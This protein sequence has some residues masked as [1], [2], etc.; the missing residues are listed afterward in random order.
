MTVRL[1]SSSL[2]AHE[3][4]MNDNKIEKPVE[5]ALQAQASI[6]SS[7]HKHGSSR[8]RGRGRDGSHY[9]KGRAGQNHGGAEQNNTG[10]NHNP[11][12]NSSWQ[13]R[14]RGRG[15]D[16]VWQ[17]NTA[18]DMD[19]KKRY[20]YVLNEDAEDGVNLETPA[21]QPEVVAPIATI[22]E[23]PRREHRQ[24]AR[25]QDYES[26]E[27]R[28]LAACNLQWKGLN[29]KKMKMTGDMVQDSKGVV[30][31]SSFPCAP[32]GRGMTEHVPVRHMAW[33]HRT[34]KR[35][36][37]DHELVGTRSKHNAKPKVTDGGDATHPTVN[38]GE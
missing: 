15:Q 19:S 5:Q 24:P 23:R 38:L 10:S 16:E 30:I 32:A 26:S 3:Q 28:A 22:N 11:S 20:I 6:G 29:L 12:S 35:L 7:Y 33:S 34:E 2:R 8:G 25:L 27:S 36:I 9:N 14:G 37:V 4:R 1:L 31:V 13:Q 21:V 17:W 18:G